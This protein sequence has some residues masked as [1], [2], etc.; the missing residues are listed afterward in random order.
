MSDLKIFLQ[1]SFPTFCSHMVGQAHLEG[2]SKFISSNYFP[3]SDGGTT[4]YI[5][6]YEFLNRYLPQVYD[7]MY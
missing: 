6:Y 5:S 1:I 2:Q 3:L 7:S 4:P